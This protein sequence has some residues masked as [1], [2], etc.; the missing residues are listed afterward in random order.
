MCWINPFDDAAA[1]VLQ[2]AQGAGQHGKCSKTL[3]PSTS[4]CS[5]CATF[6]HFCVAA[7]MS[8]SHTQECMFAL[9]IAILFNNA[10]S[11]ALLQ[12]ALLRDYLELE[13]QQPAEALGFQFDL[14]RV[15]DDFV[16]FCMLIGNDFLPCESEAKCCPRSCLKSNEHQT[17]FQGPLQELVLADHAHSSTASLLHSKSPLAS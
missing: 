4:S 15:I 13:F 10:A 16:L 12:V 1:H 14:E 5:R 6:T 9:C 3:A 2:A 8:A 17:S 7:S 11:P